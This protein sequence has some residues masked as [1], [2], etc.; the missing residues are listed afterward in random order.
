MFMYYLERTENGK[1]TKRK[2]MYLKIKREREKELNKREKWTDK[3]W[4]KYIF[5]CR[6]EDKS[7]R[8]NREK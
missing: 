8:A 2:K 4:E 5:L 6:N 1:F 7:K 3:K